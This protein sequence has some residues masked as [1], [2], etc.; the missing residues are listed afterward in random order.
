[1]N[2]TGTKADHAKIRCIFLELN[3]GKS[4]LAYNENI[5]LNYRQAKANANS[6]INMLLL[7][8]P[9]FSPNHYET[10]TQ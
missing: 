2:E 4:I 6:S 1:M 7:K 10:L 5:I 3:Y 9:Q 8:N